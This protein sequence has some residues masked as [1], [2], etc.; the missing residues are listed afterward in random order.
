M[1]RTND[2]ALNLEEAQ[3]VSSVSAVYET[4]RAALF[5]PEWIERF[6]LSETAFT[7]ARDL[8]FAP[9]VTCLLNLRKGSLEQEL[10]GF[11]ATLEGQPYASATPT[12]AALC[13]ARQR[14]SAHV[15]PALNRL[16]I[17]TWRGGQGPRLWHG[18]RLLAVDG[19]TLRLPR[20]PRLEAYFGAQ[21]HGPILARVS[22]LYDLGQ[23]L[24]LDFQLGAYC[25]SERELAIAH[26]QA[27]EAGDLILYDRGYPAFW[28]MAM[29][30][31]QGLEFCMR[32]ARGSFAAAEAFWSSEATSEIITLNPS[33]E[34]RREC[35]QQGLSTDPIRLRLVRVRLQG[36][37]TEVLATTVLEEERLPARLFK[38]LYHRRW[39]AEES[40]KRQKRWVEI[41]NVSGRSLLAVQQDVHAKILALN[42]SSLV[43]FVAQLITTRRSQQRHYRYQVRWTSTLSAMKN[44]FVRLLLAAAH[45]PVALLTTLAAKLS[46]AVEAIRPDRQF[47]RKNPGKLKP[48]FHAPYR[49]TA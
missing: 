12:P 28:L 4:L 8:P 11:F 34:Q 39:G 27:A 1:K 37:E 6:R 16:A 41:E 26:L 2:I 42:L 22:M 36:G 29:H 31:S 20:Y 48:G 7:R 18:F 32:L 25:I 38:A 14:L 10:E 49:R 23:E 30:R 24:I 40:Y 13:Q 19:S 3:S 15:F 46:A 17:A 45:A 33:S 44:T 5:S 35:R 43:R 9:L 47:P 21:A